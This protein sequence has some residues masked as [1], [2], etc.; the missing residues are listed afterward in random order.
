MELIQGL[1]LKDRAPDPSP[2]PPIPSSPWAGWWRSST[3]TTGRTSV[4]AGGAAAAEHDDGER[5]GQP[6]GDRLRHG[7]QCPAQ[8]FRHTTNYRIWSSTCWARTPVYRTSPA[9]SPFLTEKRVYMEICWTPRLSTCLTT[10]SPTWPLPED[11][12]SLWARSIEGSMSATAPPSWPCCADQDVI[13]FGPPQ[14]P[15]LRRVRHPLHPRAQL[16]VEIASVGSSASGSC[17]P[18]GGGVRGPAEGLFPRA[19]DPEQYPI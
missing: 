17:S 8:E 16:G 14:R 7:Q 3:N 19:A 9:P 2:S 15:R 6:G 18:R 4:Q 11:Q 12:A 13:R 1:S 10:T 5:G